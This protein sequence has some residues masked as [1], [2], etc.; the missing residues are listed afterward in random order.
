MKNNLERDVSQAK[1]GNKKA[2]ETIV[3]GIQNRIFGLAYRMMGDRNDAEDQTQEILIKVITHLGGFREESAFSSWVYRIA[4]NHLLT[5]LSQRNDRME[6]SFE[7]LEE[8]A[9]A[10]PATHSSLSVSGPELALL[11]EE[12]RLGCMQNVLAC[13]DGK[14]RII[15]I[16]GEI[17]EVTS[18]EGAFIFDISP[19]AFRKRLSRGRKKIQD[20]M[21]KQC[22]LVNKN[23]SCRCSKQAGRN[24][25]Q[26]LLKNRP[27]IEKEKAIESR[28]QAK[29]HLKELSEIDRTA[30][31]L[32]RY[33]E[34]QSPDSFTYI[35]KDLIASGRYQ[36]FME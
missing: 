18:N 2:L 31:M 34:Y 7:F 6:V 13:L 14:T 36:I 12:T 5:S 15:Y 19:E 11:L 22:G 32:R 4:C 25:Q 27:T 17:F 8:F 1:A 20:F 26:N 16:L 9:T 33:P 29:N 23:N 21:M 35:V 3:A 10:G 28:R 30:A 24:Q